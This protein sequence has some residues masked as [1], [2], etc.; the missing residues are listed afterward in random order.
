MNKHMLTIGKSAL[1]GKNKTQ[2]KIFICLFSLLFLLL[3]FFPQAAPPNLQYTPLENIPGFEAAS[4]TGDFYDYIQAVYKFGIWAVGISAL[5]MI[6]I[7]GFMYITSAGNNS[8]M[9][10]AKSVITDAIIG[11]VLAL[12]SYLILYIINPDLVNIQKLAPIGVAPTV[13]P[14]VPPVEGACDGTSAGCCKQGIKCVACSG[15]SSFTNNYANLCYKGAT[16]N[17]GCQLNSSLAT[18]L[19]NAN[20]DTVNAEVSEAWPPTI[21]HKSSCHQNGTCADVRCKT[22]CASASIPEIKNIYIALKNAGLSPAFESSNCNPYEKEGIHC[23][24]VSTTPSFHVN[25]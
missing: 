9:E 25:N 12:T 5:L 17:T 19:Q 15:C 10:K 7:G 13:T 1:G 23:I 3:P 4:K 16:G 2:L 21:N 20:L 6:S 14:T 18:K 8:S 22:G 24:P 11:L